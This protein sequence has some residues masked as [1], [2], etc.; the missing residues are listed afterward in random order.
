MVHAGGRPRDVSFSENEMVELGKEMV[1]WITENQNSVLHLSEWYTIHKMFTYKQWKTFIQRAEFMPYYDAALKIVGK[2]YLDKDSN[3]R[4]G[5]SERWFRVYFGDLREE[6]D[7]RA[8]MLSDLK[9]EENKVVSQ[10][11]EDGFKAVMSQ[12]SSIQSDRTIDSS[13]ISNDK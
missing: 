13:I 3:V 6:E 10:Q 9:K 8:R 5:I 12:L 2:K 11:A 7:E 1:L 4:N